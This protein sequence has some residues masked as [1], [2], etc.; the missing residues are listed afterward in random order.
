MWRTVLRGE[1][2]WGRWTASGGGEGGSLGE[3]GISD[4]EEVGSAKKEKRKKSRTYVAGIL[5]TN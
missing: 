3:G 5:L 2:L 4:T 1:E